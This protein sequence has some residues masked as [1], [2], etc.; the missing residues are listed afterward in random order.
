[1]KHAL[2]ILLA[3]VLLT[4]CTCSAV[5]GQI[6]ESVTANQKYDALIRATLEGTI[7]PE[8]GQPVTADELKAT[9]NSVRALLLNVTRA[10]YLNKKGWHQAAFA[11]ELGPD[12][13]TLDL[14]AP[15]LPE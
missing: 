9:P 11:L 8:D 2:A 13:K 5:K 4:G 10:L 15:K 1:M 7:K 3:L 6:T 12:P 14:T